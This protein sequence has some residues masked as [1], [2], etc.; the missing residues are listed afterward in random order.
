VRFLAFPLM[1]T[2]AMAG[3]G[4]VISHGIAETDQPF[5]IF[6]DILR[7]TDISG[8]VAQREGCSSLPSA[9]LDVKQGT[10]IGEAMDTFVSSNPDYTWVADDNVPNLLPAIRLPLLEKRISHLD[11][12]ATDKMTAQAVLYEIVNLP[13]VRQRSA[14]LGIKPQI[15]QGGP[16]VYDE[17]PVPKAPVPVHISLKDVS[18]REAFNAVARTYGRTVWVYIERDCD[19]EKTYAISADKD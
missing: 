11:L 16:G 4:T 15:M 1:W 9:R 14:E 18:L 12:T 2:L 5:V 6:E 3:S 17:H 10:T 8:G 19:G 13:E 7:G